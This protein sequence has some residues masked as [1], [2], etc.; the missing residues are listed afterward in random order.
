MRDVITLE[1]HFEQTLS[2]LNTLDPQAVILEG[3]CRLLRERSVGV[4]ERSVDRLV[5]VDPSQ[6]NSVK[7]QQAVTCTDFQ[8]LSCTV[9]ELQVHLRDEGEQ[10]A[11]EIAL[12]AHRVQTAVGD[13]VDNQGIHEVFD[14]LPGD[15]NSLIHVAEVDLCQ[16]SCDQA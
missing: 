1:A 8:V 2:E 11:T 15:A 6:S 3:E 10:V 4:Q 9:A 5:D 14:T 13:R 7:V 16:A 12:V